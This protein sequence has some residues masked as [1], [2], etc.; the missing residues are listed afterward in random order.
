MTNSIGEM[1]GSAVGLNLAPWRIWISTIIIKAKYDNSLLGR[2]KNTQLGITY[3]HMYI[4][5]SKFTSFYCLFLFHSFCRYLAT[6][7]YV[8]CMGW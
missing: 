3:V 1:N 4:E 8:Y 5:N 2:H 7:E 6:D